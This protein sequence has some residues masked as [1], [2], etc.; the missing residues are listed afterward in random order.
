MKKF[1]LFSILT[2]S[3]TLNLLIG[4]ASAQWWVRGGN[5]LW[6]YG[7]VEIAKDLTVSGETTLDSN[8]TVNGDLDVSGTVGGVKQYIAMIV[9]ND[10]ADPTVTELVNTTGSTFVWDNPVSGE[11]I[12]ITATPAVFT[13][14]KTS[15]ISGVLNSGGTSYYIIGSRTSDTVYTL[16]GWNP[17]GDSQVAIPDLPF[18]VQIEI[19]P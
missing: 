14:N 1:L 18:F 2:L 10:D 8:V 19:Y 6:P 13:D 11:T 7:N 9:W 5:L 4:S 16:N 15:M 12:T 3:L 17:N